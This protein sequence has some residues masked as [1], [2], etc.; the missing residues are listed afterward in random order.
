[1]YTLQIFPPHLQYVSFELKKW[2]NGDEYCH[3]EHCDYRTPGVAISF[4][5][6]DENEVD[7]YSEQNVPVMCQ[8]S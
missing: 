1:M 8:K 6:S 4:C 5:I 2:R 3:K 7:V